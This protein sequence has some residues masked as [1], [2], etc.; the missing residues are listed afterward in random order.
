MMKSQ[1]STYSVPNT[2]GGEVAARYKKDHVG[3]GTSH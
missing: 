3:N 2:S 1:I